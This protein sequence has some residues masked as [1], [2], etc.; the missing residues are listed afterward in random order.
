[1]TALKYQR[2]RRPGNKADADIYTSM[3]SND[4]PTSMYALLM[5]HLHADWG[6]LQ[7]LQ[8]VEYVGKS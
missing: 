5:R 8:M 4:T 3:V 6:K 7:E 2:S 1:M